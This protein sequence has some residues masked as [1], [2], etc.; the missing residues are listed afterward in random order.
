M[1]KKILK[2]AGFNKLAYDEAELFLYSD[3]IFNYKTFGRKL[4][5]EPSTPLFTISNKTFTSADWI[6]FAQT[7]RFKSDGSGVKPYPSL[8]DEFI[9][10]S[11]FDYYQAHLED[12]NPDFRNQIIEFKEGN[13]FF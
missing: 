1:P 12:F 8:F 4:N 3:S 11:T 10:N 6:G 13:L 2:Q 9:E 7:F 5:I